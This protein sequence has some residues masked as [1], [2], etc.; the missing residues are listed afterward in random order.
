MHNQ[1]EFMTGAVVDGG[2]RLTSARRAIIDTLVAS[3]GHI[4]ADALVEMVRREAP[5]IGRMTV[6]R[7]LDLLTELGVIHPIYQG[8]GAASFILL[9]DG[10]HHHMICN[11]CHVVIEFDHCT[12]NEI[13]QQLADRYQFQISSHLLELHGVCQ[14]CLAG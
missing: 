2:Y 7:T 1:V 12:A 11:R 5:Q 3:G 14:N 9:P 8:T 10:S 13:S 4:T 6:Y